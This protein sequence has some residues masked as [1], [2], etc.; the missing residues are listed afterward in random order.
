LFSGDLAFFAALREFFQQAQRLLLNQ[1]LFTEKRKSRDKN[2]I[3][4]ELD[5]INQ[6]I[7]AQE[8]LRGTLPDEQLAA[9]LAPLRQK[10]AELT[11]QLARGAAG[12]SGAVAQGPGAKAVGE[13]GVM[14][15]G[16][17]G[18]SIIT[19]D[20]GHVGGI[21]ADRIEAENVVQGMQ[22]LGGD[23]SST[24]GTVALA[25]ALSRG[26]ITADSIQARNVV[27]GFQY[28]ADPA[29]ATP[30]ELRQEVARLRQQL[31]EA[32]AAGEIEAT[33]DASAVLST[34]I[35]DAQESLER[36]ETE[37]AQATPQGSRVMRRLKDAAEILTES[38]RTAEAAGKLGKT[39][40]PLVPAAAALY[41][42]AV[43]LFGG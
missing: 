12:G 5:K 26:S 30:D 23:L 13:R 38:A 32:V 21:R 43:K 35:E 6:A 33:A 29:Q 42:I 24:A 3:Q 10:Q 27:A 20:Q 15:G 11:A 18:G 28:I 34:S 31:A 41:Q 19:G 4:T 36:A 17:V 25:E 37:L 22:Q 8:A 7:S 1:L 2:Q 14:V 39:L 40:A 9:M 16:N